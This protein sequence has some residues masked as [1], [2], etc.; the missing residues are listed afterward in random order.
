LTP[1]ATAISMACTYILTPYTLY[2][3]PYTLYSH[4]LHTI[5]RAPARGRLVGISLV[6]GLGSSHQYSGACV[7]V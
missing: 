7:C 2:F 1:S 6:S 5:S 3:T 4:T